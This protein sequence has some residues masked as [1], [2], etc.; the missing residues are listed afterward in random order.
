MIYYIYILCFSQ[1]SHT[2]SLVYTV[3]VQ[4]N[5][6]PDQADQA[7]QV[8]IYNQVLVLVLVL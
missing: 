8:I 4:Y 1:M 2:S 6:A 7:C 3:P 5:Q